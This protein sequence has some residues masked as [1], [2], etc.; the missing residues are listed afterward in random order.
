MRTINREDKEILFFAP[1]CALMLY[2][3][4]LADK[5][6]LF[7]NKNLGKV[8]LLLTCCQH[9]AHLPENS[10][11]INVCPGCDLRYRKNYEGVATI[12]LWEVINQGNFTDFPDYKG[13]RMSIIDACPTR[14]DERIHN[15]LRNI[16]LKMNIS[17]VEPRN[18]RKEST[19]CGDYYY[20]ALPTGKV[21]EL[22]TEKAT[23]MPVNDIVV[24]C[25]SCVI[26]VC[27]G[28]KEPHYL[29]DLLFNEDSHP[30]NID[31]DDWHKVLTEFIESH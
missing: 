31:L 13:K 11:V 6:L 14:D 22:M 9:N 19:C 1:G 23:E 2:K 17:L 10:R 20:G 3:P 4:E 12:S 28:G 26:A 27:N 8:E 18:T 7:L 5:I 30:Q 25:V 24:H 15:A 16:M 29:A 21:K